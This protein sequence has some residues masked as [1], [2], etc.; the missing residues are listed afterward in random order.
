MWNYWGISDH[1]AVLTKAS[2]N[3]HR[4]DPSKRLI[5]LW[6]K[7]DFNI[8]RQNMQSFI[9]DYITN[10]STQFLP[11]SMCYGTNLLT[12]VIIVWS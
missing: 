12:F 7:A 9:Q 8:I 2:I 3:I 5:Y 11:L 6:S 4:Q 1:E 10:Y